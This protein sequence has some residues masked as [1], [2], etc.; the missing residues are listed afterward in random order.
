MRSG[1]ERTLAAQLKRAKVAFEYEGMKIPYSI[2]HT[3][4]PDFVLANGVIIEAKGYF[5]TP[6]EPRKMRAVKYQHPHL[7]IRFVFMNAGRKIP[8]QKTT[9]AQWATRHGFPWADGEIPEE[10]LHT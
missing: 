6:D 1:F 7:D 4:S 3:Y 9:H 5:R 10:W 2:E 8:G